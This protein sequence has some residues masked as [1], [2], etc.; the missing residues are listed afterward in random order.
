[1]FG[2]DPYESGAVTRGPAGPAAQPAARDRLGLAF[3]PEDRR[4]QGLVMDAP[5]SRNI[6][7]A[8]RGGSPA[9]G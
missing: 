3:V 2:V 6:T 4:K 8:M 7:L 1:M 5:I 9:S